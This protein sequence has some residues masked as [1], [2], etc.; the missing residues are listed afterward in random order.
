M[1]LLLGV[2]GMLGAPISLVLMVISLIRKK[3]VKNKIIA[4][5]AF[6]I[7]FIVG[8]MITPTN[9]TPEAGSEQQVTSDAGSAK[10]TGSADPQEIKP[11]TTA[12]VDSIAQKAKEAAKTA[13]EA[14]LNTAY[15]YI[16]DTYTN[17]FVNNETME[18]MMYYG[19]L[20]EYAYEGKESMLNY[21]NVGQ[22]AEQLVK[23]V[24]RGNEKPE[25]EGP[26]ENI[27]QIKD[28]IEKIDKETAEKAAAEEKAKQ[29]AAEKAAAEEKA[30]QEAAAAQAEPEE[31]EITV[32]ITDTGSKYHSSGCRTLKKSRIETTLKKAI[33]NG[34]EPCGICHPPTQ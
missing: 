9:T 25:D 2:I 17:C 30:K 11:N 32:Y 20:M 13:S 27:Q 31:Q 16:H 34:Y 23:Y 7:I 19:W 21:Y 6:Y 33:A 5:I 12:M 3:P 22:D 10:D 4:I 8:I 24:Y 29:E 28:S 14:D 1:G 15:T 26:Q 18:Q